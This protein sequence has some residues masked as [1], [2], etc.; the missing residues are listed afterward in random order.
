MLATAARSRAAVSGRGFVIPDDVK[1][2]AAPTL[3]HRILL[4]PE[5]EIQGLT[6]D[7]VIERVLGGLEVPR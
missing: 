3:R 5:A 7:D 4:Q 2:L 1:E 6:A